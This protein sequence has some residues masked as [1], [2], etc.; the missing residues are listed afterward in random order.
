MLCEFCLYIGCIC[1]TVYLCGLVL[2]ALL[3]ISEAKIPCRI[4]D[5]KNI[6]PPPQKIALQK[7]RKKLDLIY[8]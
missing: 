6:A 2:A 4:Q 5:C 1:H 7:V 3:L 8:E